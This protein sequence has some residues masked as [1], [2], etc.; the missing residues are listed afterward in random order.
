M[1]KA[2]CFPVPNE[3]HTPAIILKDAEDIFRY[4]QLQSKLFREVRVVDEDD[5]IVV[6]IIDGLY[7]FP[8]EWK[9]FNK[10]KEEKK[11]GS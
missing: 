2:Y 4:T 6:Q 10:L 1:F 9:K 11:S 3:W 7:T 5:F 8:E